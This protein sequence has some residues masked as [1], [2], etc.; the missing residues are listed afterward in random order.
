[1]FR[2]FFHIFFFFSQTQHYTIFQLGVFNSGSAWQWNEQ[3]QQYYY[4]AFQVKQPDLNYRCPMVVEEIKVGTRFWVMNEKKKMKITQISRRAHARFDREPVQNS[5]LNL[6]HDTLL[7]WT[8]RRR[9]QIRRCQ[10]SVRE[11]RFS[12]RTEVR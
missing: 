3:R 12:W 8:R 5:K 7:A 4:H 11:G 2:I 1:M 9:L 6:E 10:L